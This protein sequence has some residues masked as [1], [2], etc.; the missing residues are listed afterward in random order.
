MSN[1][2]NTP[3]TPKTP[4]NRKQPCREDVLKMFEAASRDLKTDMRKSMLAQ[5]KTHLTPLSNK[6]KSERIKRS[7][8]YNMTEAEAIAVEEAEQVAKKQKIEEQAANKLAREQKKFFNATQ[9]AENAQKR[10]EKKI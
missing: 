10:E 1:I 6:E 7:A 4:H 5:V 9:K 8:N 3:K 2:S